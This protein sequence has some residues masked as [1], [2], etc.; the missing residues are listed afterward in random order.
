MVNMASK[1]SS[2]L[3]NV[4]ESKQHV[5]FCGPETA[6]IYSQT[7]NFEEVLVDTALTNWED[8]TS[9][10]VQEDK[11]ADQF[12]SGIE[13]MYHKY[14]VVEARD[15]QAEYFRTLRKP[16]KSDPLTH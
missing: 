8:I 16:I 7:L 5:I 3:K 9:T 14:I 11:T 4:S 2:T 10:K 6:P 12:D 15:T 13:E 1:L